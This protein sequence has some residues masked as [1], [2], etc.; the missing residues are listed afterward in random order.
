VDWL[1]L[2]EEILNGFKRIGIF[3]LFIALGAGIVWGF[4]SIILIAS[5]KLPFSWWYTPCWLLLLCT[6]AGV[7]GSWEK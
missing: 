2:L 7:I 5:G 3:I 4:L 6:I 1:E